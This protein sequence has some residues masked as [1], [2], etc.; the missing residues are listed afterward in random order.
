MFDF[1]ERSS[2]LQNELITAVKRFIV[3]QDAK[4]ICGW[5]TTKS[6]QSLDVSG[7]KWRHAIQHNDTQHNDTQHNGTQHNGRIFSCVQ[8][9]YE[10]AVSNL[11]RP[12]H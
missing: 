5:F 3:C 12:M 11:D 4:A 1:D 8:P 2:L 6:S 9:S 10:R 7:K